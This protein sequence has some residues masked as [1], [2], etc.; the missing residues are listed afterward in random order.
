[1]P[2]PLGSTSPLKALNA[3]KHSVKIGPRLD[4]LMKRRSPDPIPG[5][6]PAL[7]QKWL[8]ARLFDVQ[9]VNEDAAKP[10]PPLEK[11]AYEGILRSFLAV[12]VRSGS[13]IS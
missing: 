8:R 5:P 2:M 7:F 6:D 10:G 1:M 9:A 4:A 12:N 3:A 11:S 13:G